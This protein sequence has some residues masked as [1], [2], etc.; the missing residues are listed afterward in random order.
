MTDLWDSKEFD[1]GMTTLES[2]ILHE[3]RYFLKPNLA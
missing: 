3:I 2:T 1:H